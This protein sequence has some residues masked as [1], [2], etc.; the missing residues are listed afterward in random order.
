MHQFVIEVFNDIL[1][2]LGCGTDDIMGEDY[3]KFTCKLKV[4]LYANEIST[5]NSYSILYGKTVSCCCLLY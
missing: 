4:F 2:G 3:H 5:V 1:F